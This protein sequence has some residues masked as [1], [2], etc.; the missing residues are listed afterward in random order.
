MLVQIKSYLLFYLII[1]VMIFIALVSQC[2]A[3]VMLPQIY[4]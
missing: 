4:R 1:V 2:L 3:I